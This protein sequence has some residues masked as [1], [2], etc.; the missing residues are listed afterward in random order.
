MQFSGILFVIY[1]CLSL[2]RLVDLRAAFRRLHVTEPAADIQ[3]PANLQSMTSP[4]R[5]HHRAKVVRKPDAVAASI[6]SPRSSV[7]IFS[8]HRRCELRGIPLRLIGTRG[9]DEATSE[10]V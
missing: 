8:L 10:G 5:S 3:I 7:I 4:P 2:E 1:R 9:L 6:K